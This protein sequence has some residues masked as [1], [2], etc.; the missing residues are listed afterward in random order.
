MPAR[1]RLA[2]LA[3]EQSQNYFLEKKDTEVSTYIIHYLEAVC[4]LLK[5]DLKSS[6]LLRRPASAQMS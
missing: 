5:P 2:Q 4:P 3:S 6:P 1:K